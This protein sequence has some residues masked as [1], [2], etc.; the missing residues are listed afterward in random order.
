MNSQAQAERE[1]KAKI[2]SKW[3]H[4]GRIISLRSDRIQY[5]NEPPHTYDIVTHP[6][7]VFLIPVAEDGE[8]F[9]VR[10]WRRAI[11]KIIIELPAGTL[12]A[13]ETPEECAQ[14][15]LQEE[16]G[17]KADVLIPLGGFYTAPGFCN[18][19][20]H[21]FIAKK[22]QKSA[23][24]GDDTHLI[25]L[26]KVSPQTALKMIESGEICDAKTIVGVLRYASSLL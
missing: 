1:K 9:F 24:V 16:I 19:Y 13:G 18:E 3:I 25:D 7:A 5:Q 23:L 11:Q 6:G 2:E 8:I 14:R 12:D 17:Y 10:Q 20:L 26:F 21:Y 22:L 15:E 4:H